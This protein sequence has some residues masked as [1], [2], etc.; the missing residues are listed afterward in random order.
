[1]PFLCICTALRASFDQKIAHSYGF[2]INEFKRII[3]IFVN[4]LDVYRPKFIIKYL[5][6]F[7]VIASL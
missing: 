1:M 3:P 4:R 6:S 7:L 2:V 5:C